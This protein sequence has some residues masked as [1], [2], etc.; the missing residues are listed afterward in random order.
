M[1]FQ[2]PDFGNHGV[3]LRYEN[4]EVNVYGTPDGLLKF[5]R[6]IEKLVREGKETH[7]HLEDYDI[8]TENSLPGDIALFLPDA[9]K[10][11]TD[12]K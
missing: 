11:A 8:L 7:I 9:S 5:V 3:E 12:A 10:K 2:K 6:L 1:G 4:N